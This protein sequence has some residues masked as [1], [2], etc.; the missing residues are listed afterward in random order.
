MGR[1][2]ASLA[3]TCAVCAAAHGGLDPAHVVI[4]ANRQVPASGELAMH[5]AAGRGV[6]TNHIVLLDLPA[7]ESISRGFYEIRLRD[8]LLQAL[9]DRGLVKQTRRP[10]A[11]PEHETAWTTV[12]SSVAAIVSMF[13][14]PLRIE[15]TKPAFWRRAAERLGNPA[16]RDGAAV[17]SELA[18]LLAPPYEIRGRVPN[19]LYGFHEWVP[20]QATALHVLVAARLD[21][22]DPATVRRMIDDAVAAGQTG[23]QGRAYVDSRPSLGAGFQSAASGMEDVVHRLRRDGFEV[24]YDFQPALWGLA[25]PMEDAAWYFGWYAPDATGPF[26]RP[27]RRFVPGA[28][29]YHLHSLGAASLRTTTSHWA[30][31]LLASGAACTIGAV[32]EPYLVAMPDI[33]ALADRL[34][35]GFTFGESAMLSIPSL[36]WQITVVGDPLYRPCPRGLEEVVRSLARDTNAPPAWTA[37]R[38]ANVL[39]QDGRVQPA[40]ELLLRRSA[41]GEPP[42]LLRE[43]AADLMLLNGRLEDAAREYDTVIHE[44]PSAEA[45]ARAGR[46]LLPV[47]RHLGRSNDVERVRLEASAKWPGHP[48][49]RV[50]VDAP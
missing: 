32:D 11:A 2:T 13:G 22:P 3:A 29:A 41:A 19:P 48:C 40:L 28:I 12:E 15:D 34:C 30:G 4:V 25:H 10:G 31:A 21:G 37:L 6:P 33:A 1:L 39:A 35:R 26:L 8:P 16:D 18:L 50:M 49:L 24:E 9:R 23:L 44:A 47:L 20:P 42:P 27:G 36:S 7:A 5:Y 38:L 43:R 45:A 17:D 46:K 14:V